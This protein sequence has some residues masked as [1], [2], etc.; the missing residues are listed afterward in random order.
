M[1]NL[2]FVYDAFFVQQTESSKPLILFAAP[3]PEIEQWVGVPQRSRLDDGETVGFQRQE[4]RAR[5]KELAGFFDEERNVVQNPLLA[6]LQDSASIEFVP[7]EGHPSFGSL[8]IVT[9]SLTELT[10]REL[11][12]RVISRLVARVPALAEQQIDP[13]RR[14]RLIERASEI[15]ELESEEEVDFE[16]SSLEE[17]EG[18]DEDLAESEGANTD[19]G[20][21]LLTEETQL[22]DFYQE[23]VLRAEILGKLASN[24]NPSELLGFTKE[25][26]IGYLQ[27]VVLVDGQH[28]LRGAVLSASTAADTD[29]GRMEI[30]SAIDAGVEP[31]EAHHQVLMANA[32][33]L[34]VSLLLDDSPS[35]HVFQF[36][37]VNQ[38]AT[39]MTSA[40]LGT[41]VST[42]LSREELDP[43]AKRLMNA[44]IKLEDSQAVAYLTR[45]SDSPFKGLVQTG[46]TGDDTGFLPWTVLNGLTS[47]FRE[48]KGGKLYHQQNDYA[49]IW[50]KRYLK[51]SSFVSE[52]DDSL[53][54]FNI[55]SAPDGPW[56]GVFVRFYSLI[57]ENFG[58][59]DPGTPNYWGNTRSNLFNKISLTIL[60]ADFFQYLHERQLT[61]SSVDDVQEYTE[62]WLDDVDRQYFAREW[63]M[64]GL[65]KDQSAV[66]R[67]WAEVWFE[68]RKNPERLPRVDSY[69]P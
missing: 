24:E 38:K 52:A 68:Y 34:P 23:L 53:A 36:V 29:K 56:R 43:V 13:A 64:G 41:I 6:A 5:V 65:K 15:H 9:E 46:I 55:W 16:V 31:N 22:V 11:I 37:V 30:R 39:P 62:E 4:N 35:E 26:M 18:P 59:D 48:L 61:L 14:Q 3:A 20:S 47:I 32:R 69:K 58:S 66:Q 49:S 7:T 45:S 1:P 10:L 19:V 2:S 44:G 42:S 25:A 28:R 51:D 21:V 60:A 50:R 40:L 67:K 57:K 12:E 27:P 54:K 17:D 33:S 8:K 63:R